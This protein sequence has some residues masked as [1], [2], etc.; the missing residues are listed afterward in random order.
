VPLV[1]SVRKQVLASLVVVVACWG[2]FAHVAQ[3]T[4]PSPFSGV[5]GSPFSTPGNAS[6]VAFDPSGRLLATADGD[7]HV[8]MDTIAA[9]GVPT[10]VPGSPFAVGQSSESVSFAPDGSL[11]AVA[12]P[13]ADQVDVLSVGPDGDLA[14]VT[15]SPFDAGPAGTGPISVA[16]SPN[17]HLLAVSDYGTNVHAVSMYTVG[18]GGGLTPVAGSPYDLGA[19]NNPFTVTLSP[20][21]TLLATANQDGDT[22]SVFRVGT[23]GGLTPVA[24]SP[25]S[26]GSGS[27]PLSV[28]FSADGE[29]LASA[30]SNSGKVSMFSVASDG[31]LSEVDGSPFPSGGGPRG[32]AFGPGGLL[33][34]ANYFGYSVSVFSVSS[35]GAL[36]AVAGSPFPADSYPTSVAF[37]S[38]AGAFAISE[39]FTGV[40]LF[41][42]G[43]PLAEISSPS[44]GQTYALHQL[45]STDFGCT[46][47]VGAPGLA[48]CT[49]SG[50]AAGSPATSGLGGAGVLD[51]SSIGAHTYTITATS[52]DT[53]TGTAAIHYTVAAAPIADINAP[54]DGGAYSTGQLV[55]TSFRCTDGADGPGLTSCTDSQGDSG[56]AGTVDTTTPGVHSYTVTATSGD[57]QTS[58]ATI[59]YTVQ[60]ATSPTLPT[61]PASTTSTTSP[62]IS[63][64]PVPAPTGALT[65]HQL[66]HAKLGMTR[67]QASGAYPLHS[68]HGK[69]YEEFFRLTTAGMRVGY[70]SETLLAMLPLQMR[71]GLR[72][73][74]VLVLTA[75]PYYA[76]SGVRSGTAFA[77]ARHTLG[78]GDLFQIGLN[79][80]YLKSYGSWTAVLKVRNGIVQ[81]VGI[82][83][84]GVTRNRATQRRFITSFS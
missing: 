67:A 59:H 75:N 77:A 20:D 72:G 18:T 8:S 27:Q 73:T 23:G 48:S 31:Q 32:V 16:F 19:G 58:T 5:S 29:L 51:T 38:S 34:V 76:L 40:G 45:V 53:L 69:R 84:S 52:T 71:P 28:A 15:G 42:G 83:D 80:W 43:A 65:Q 44:N 81:E 4:V 3:A 21:G 36:T 22:V 82:A 47:P 70:A 2:A 37:S 26:T 35:A 10:A 55:A 79:L 39:L 60:A 56:T 41:A 17:G 33:A 61:P 9:G 14:P 68:T 49:D 50:G 30:D 7:G 12:D 62:V 24:G 25:Y 74:V 13:N 6:V 54:A 57:G 11:L 78:P 63:T 64:T 1:V 46:E 66:G